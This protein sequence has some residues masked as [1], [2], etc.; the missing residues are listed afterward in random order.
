MA[1]RHAAEIQLRAPQTAD[2]MHHGT[3]SLLTRAEALES[4]DF[5]VIVASV[6]V[7]APFHGD[8]AMAEIPQGL[9]LSQRQAHMVVEGGGEVGSFALDGGVQ[10][11]GERVEN[12]ADGGFLLHGEAER[13]ADVGVE[14]EE[15]VRAVDGIDDE[16]RRVG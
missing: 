10:V 14:V 2:P 12:D 9:R 4:R 8:E 15:V 1:R 16:R 5:N 6:P 11:V 3:A 7:A 13:D